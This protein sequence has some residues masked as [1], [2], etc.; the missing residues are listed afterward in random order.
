MDVMTIR[1]ILTSA[2]QCSHYAI[3]EDVQADCLE[4][5]LIRCDAR[6]CKDRSAGLLSA[7]RIHQDDA[8]GAVPTGE[9]QS[10]PYVMILDRNRRLLEWAPIRLGNGGLDDL[11]Y[12][13]LGGPDIHQDDASGMIPTGEEQSSSHAL[14]Q[15]RNSRLLE[16]TTIRLVN[17]GPEAPCN[18]PKNPN[19]HNFK[20]AESFS[21]LGTNSKPLI[22][23]GEG[24]TRIVGEGTEEEG[25]ER[26]GRRR[27]G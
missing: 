8:S 18:W 11:Q 27:R 25:E 24:D 19:G 21:T 12:G 4:G 15:D 23:P 6:C 17:G 9:G 22:L 14:L 20:T 2:E 1:G 26:G 3:L 10:T 7:P 16:W 13:L 5:G